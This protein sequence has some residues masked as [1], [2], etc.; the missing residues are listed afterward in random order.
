MRVGPS[1]GT[2]DGAI[3]IIPWSHR[4][5]KVR[6]ALGRLIVFPPII[7]SLSFYEFYEVPCQGRNIEMI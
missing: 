7:H 1:V 2:G 3:L 5:I 6:G 4:G